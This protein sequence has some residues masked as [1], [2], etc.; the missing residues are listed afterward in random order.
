MDPIKAGI[1]SGRCSKTVV[2]EGP[3]DAIV[4]GFVAFDLG[5]KVGQER[6]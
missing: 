2:K 3:E 1:H 5:T 6:Q 4:T